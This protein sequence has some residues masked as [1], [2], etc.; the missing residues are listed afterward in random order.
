MR[1]TYIRL[2]NFVGIRAGLGSPD[3]ELDLGEEGNLFVMLSGKNGS[4]KTSILSALHPFAGT[5]DVRKSPVAEDSEAYKEVRITDGDDKYVIKHFYTKK[6]HQSYIEMNGEEL[7]GNGGVK[8]FEEIVWEKLGCSK[9]YARIGRLG[10]NVS[11]FID[12]PTAQRK[13]YVSENFLPNIDDYLT[14]F[15]NVKEK[16]NAMK[17]QVKYVS[18]QLSKLDDA[19]VLEQLKATSE[20]RLAELRA[21]EVRL[22]EEAAS[23]TALAADLRDRAS[24]LAGKASE[25]KRCQAEMDLAAARMDELLSEYPMLAD[26]DREKAEAALAKAEER[27]ESRSSEH[28]VKCSEIKSASERYG[29]ARAAEEKREASLKRVGATGKSLAGMESLREE[30]SGK[31]AEAKRS[32]KSAPKDV[33]VLE[34]VDSKSLSALASQLK[35]FREF[36]AKLKSEIPEEEREEVL[37]L[38]P[39]GF[40]VKEVTRN[41]LAVRRCVETASKG[42]SEATGVLKEQN[43]G[44][45]HLETLEKRPG[46]CKIDSCAFIK[47]ALEFRD[48]VEAISETEATVALWRE[49]LREA[50][51]EDDKWELIKGLVSALDN[52]VDYMLVH[53]GLLTKLGLWDSVSTVA[54][55][56]ALSSSA[57]DAELDRMFD[58]WPVLTRVTLQEEVRAETD[59]LER[60]DEQIEAVRASES[61][62][63]EI[64]GE[65]AEA[66]AARESW[67]QEHASLVAQRDLIMNKL[68]I[69]R[70]RVHSLQKFIDITDE[71]ARAATENAALVKSAGKWQQLTEKAAEHETRASAARKSVV[72]LVQEMDPIRK[73]I[74]DVDLRLSKRAEFEATLASLQETFQHYELIRKALD[75]AKGI[76]LFFVQEYL[77]RTR[78]ICNSLLKAA[79]GDALRIHCF[80]LSEKDF[81]IK[82]ATQDGQLLEDVK[83]ASQGEVALVTIALSLSMIEQSMAR[84]NV[85]SLDELDGPLDVDNRKGFVEMVRTMADRLGIEQIFVIS[86]NGVFEQEVADMVLLRGSNYDDEDESVTDGKRVLYDGR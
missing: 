33:R 5:Q 80:D 81:L 14:A 22:S 86:H 69:A 51:A 16:H 46:A 67:E 7:N 48:I 61:A 8:T 54:R 49:S 9:E 23:D 37:S 18:D 17:T 20:A 73:A 77:K 52:R 1:I 43:A 41:S 82:V 62:S 72:K 60:L 24:K 31:L 32:L 36:I 83:L 75:P 26:C 76:P 2:K 64:R 78:D 84:Y 15:K 50:K 21:E 58:V 6:A 12:L 68:T 70:L 57:T 4:G 30:I 34:G 65:L 28:A 53:E 27:A 29:E 66:R 25:H 10:S 59:R 42:L 13:E 71:A 45:V 63:E 19:A 74:R 39:L 47:K 11:S 79:C 38:F 44:L 3:F 85:L 35:S 40:G 56:W 55:A